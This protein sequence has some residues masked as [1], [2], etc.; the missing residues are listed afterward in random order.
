MYLAVER[1]AG[2]TRYFIRESYLEG[3]GWLSRDLFHLARHP[4]TYVTYAADYAYYLDEE[5]EKGIVA[6]GNETNPHELDRLFWPF[7]RPEVR[8]RVERFDR[9]SSS[10]DR[11]RASQSEFYEMY[12]AIH[13][14]DKRR[15]HYL[16]LGSMDQGKLYLQTPRF[17]NHLLHKSRDELEQMFLEMEAHLRPREYKSYVYV[18]FDLQRHFS[19][20]LTRFLPFSLDQERMERRFLEELC[21]L[22]REESYRVGYSSDFMLK[23]YL[24]RYLC[25]FF[26]TEFSTNDLESEFIRMFME[27]R[28]A[29]TPPPPASCI[30]VSEAFTIM[31]INEQ[32]F[33]SMSRDALTKTF[34]RKAHDH[35]PDKGGAHDDFVRLANA[36][37]TLQ[38]LKKSPQR[39]FRRI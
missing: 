13:I 14:F 1:I 32:E 27:N 20:R 26:D 11:K 19:H 12:R 5:I 38:N 23:M 9:S 7:L 37:R 21:A 33:K 29:F 17:F 28:R 10:R 6:G 31:G 16:R 30:P 4:S 15:M 39:R 18:I 22:S 35:H 8:A 36:Y 34:R 24:K 2:K 25:M 3:D